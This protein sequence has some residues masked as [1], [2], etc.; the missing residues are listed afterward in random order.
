MSN[1]DFGDSWCVK[2]TVS[3]DC[4]DL[5]RDGRI[6]QEQLDKA[7]IKC[8]ELYRPVTLAVDGEM[9]MDDVGG[10]GGFIDFLKTIN[11]EL[12]GMDKE[13]KELAK[14]EKKEMLDWAKKVQNWKKLNPMI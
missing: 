10:M 13:E 1:Y 3:K 4:E 9:L 7:Q 14:T 8:R 2:I 5:V 11:P 6:T 12:D